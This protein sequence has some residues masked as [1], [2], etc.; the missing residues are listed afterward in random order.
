MGHVLKTERMRVV[1]RNDRGVVT[2]RKTF[3][4]GDTVSASDFP[5]S[6]RFDHLVDK[7]VLVDEEE[8]SGGSDA[9]LHDPAVQGRGLGN[10][11]A[12]TKTTLDFSGGLPDGVV[13]NSDGSFTISGAKAE[14]LS[15]A[16]EEGDFDDEEESDD[17]DEGGTSDPEPDYESMEYSDLQKQ[18]KERTGDGSGGKDALIARLKG[19]DVIDRDADE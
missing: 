7:G 2:K 12:T 9:N 16:I 17:E 4:R 10:S 5:E 8:F 6:S 14:E 15:K 13:K 1:H 18:A 11:N 19:Q 3:K